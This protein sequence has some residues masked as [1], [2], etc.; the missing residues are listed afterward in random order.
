MKS[1][2]GIDLGGTNIKAV[3][4]TEDGAVRARSHVATDDQGGATTPASAAGGRSAAAGVAW[5]ERVR[6]VLRDL[7]TT[8]GPAAAVG[9]SAPG[10]ASP[11]G[12]RIASMQGRMAGLQGLDWTL[13]L[14]R[15]VQVL[16]DAHAALLGEIWLGAAANARNAVLIT[17]GTGVGGAIVCDGRLLKGHIGR[18]GHLG[19][20]A[21]GTDGARDIV[22]TPDSLEDAIGEC[23]IRRRTDG[24]FTTTRALIAAAQGGDDFATGV[25]LRSV[26]ALAAGIAS[27]INVVDPEVVILGG[28]IAKSGPALFEP[29]E[30][31]LAEFEWRPNEHRVRIVTARLGHEAGAFGAAYHAMDRTAE[32][33]E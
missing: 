22:N 7:E 25:W 8:G 33:A 6:D 4:V 1:A 23:T 15:P 3:A 12:R 2:I 10:L 11:D 32:G 26:K 21:L 29:L 20:I 14:G 19:H 28:G 18:A 27:I 17:L 9:L 16:N 30:R 24:R 31:F 13:F 5:P